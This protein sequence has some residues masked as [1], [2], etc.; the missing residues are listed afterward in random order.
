MILQALHALYYRK[1]DEMPP[2]GFEFKE[3]PFLIVI[4]GEGRF[5]S[6]QDTR[7]KVGRKLIG[8]KYLVPKELGEL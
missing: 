5:V 8:R 1:Q 3:L 4:N 7:T 2:Q 6:L